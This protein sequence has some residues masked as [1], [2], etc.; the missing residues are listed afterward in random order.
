LCIASL[1]ALR[2]DIEY[3]PTEVRVK[4]HPEIV[5]AMADH[6]SSSWCYYCETSLDH[7]LFKAPQSGDK[8][9]LSMRLGSQLDAWGSPDSYTTQDI[10]LNVDDVRRAPDVAF[11]T[12]SPSRSQKLHPLKENC[13]LPQLWIEICY[14]DDVTD[15]KNAMSKV[16]DCVIPVNGQSRCSILV[17]C[18][19][20]EVVDDVTEERIAYNI[21]INATT[22][23]AAPLLD[24]MPLDEPCVAYWPVETAYDDM[25]W[26]RIYRNH[27]LDVVVPNTLTP[28]R[29]DMNTVIS[30]IYE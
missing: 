23:T 12:T 7:L 27:H 9:V 21:P 22:T 16:R 6:V 14:V 18:I 2:D 17:I 30:V 4:V 19:S 5:I 25:Q 20:S 1:D 8:G 28:F 10:L 29:F 26:Y 11:W 15:F 24:V 3:Q 13:P